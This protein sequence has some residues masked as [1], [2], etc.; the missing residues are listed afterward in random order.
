MILYKRYKEMLISCPGPK[1]FGQLLL[2]ADLC[3]SGP[4]ESV[5]SCPSLNYRIPQI[6]NYLQTLS[7]T[8]L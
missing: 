8:D 4:I 2:R 6:A 5:P 7:A 1:F 3:F